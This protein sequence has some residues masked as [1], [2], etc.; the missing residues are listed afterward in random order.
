LDAKVTQKR[1][2]EYLTGISAYAASKT[3][4]IL[5]AAALARRYGSKSIV[6]LSVDIGGGAADT[7]LSAHFT[8]EELEPCK[9]SRHGAPGIR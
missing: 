6:G 7:N 2:E 5:F 8:D 1:P 9:L 3:A 4:D